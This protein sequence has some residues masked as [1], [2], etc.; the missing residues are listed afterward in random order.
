MPRDMSSDVCSSDLTVSSSHLYGRPKVARQVRHRERSPRPQPA[1]V[2]GSTSPSTSEPTATAERTRLWPVTVAPALSPRTPLTAHPPSP[3][4]EAI[5]AH[6]GRKGTPRCLTSAS[7]RNTAPGSR[8]EQVPARAGPRHTGALE[9]SLQRVDLPR[10][11]PAPA[12]EVMHLA[13]EL[14]LPALLVHDPLRS[15]GGGT[16]VQVLTVTVG[17]HRDAELRPVEVHPDVLTEAR[18]PDPVLQLWGGEPELL[19]HQSA[20]RLQRT[21]GQRGGSL[22]HRCYGNLPPVGPQP[23]V[24]AVQVCQ[25]QQRRSLRV[26]RVA[27][28]SDGEIGRASCRERE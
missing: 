20:D 14:I 7:V 4:I 15:S 17:L 24:G 1:Q 6:R 10:L 5:S 21:I 2:S 23:L 12:P 18:Q 27:Q 28:C 11:V 26:R 3:R 9:L 19:D 16:G 22:E 13:A 25:S 8:H